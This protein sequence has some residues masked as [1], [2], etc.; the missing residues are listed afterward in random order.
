MIDTILPHNGQVRRPQRAHWRLTLRMYWL[1]NRE[2]PAK[3]RNACKRRSSSLFLVVIEPSLNA[4][5][6]G[7]HKPVPIGR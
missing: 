6:N 5:M 4:T 2:S 3:A 1:Q 7:G